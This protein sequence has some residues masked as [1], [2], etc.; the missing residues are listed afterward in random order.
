MKLIVVHEFGTYKRGAEV[1]DPDE[2][3]EILAGSNAHKVVKVSLP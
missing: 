2:I 1:T 3:K